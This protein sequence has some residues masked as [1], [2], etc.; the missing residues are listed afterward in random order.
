M[1]QTWSICD[2]QFRE[3]RGQS[4]TNAPL[5]RMEDFQPAK[6]VGPVW[7]IVEK[8]SPPADVIPIDV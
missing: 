7:I 1:P 5:R 6:Q 2:L 4:R 3:P 8:D